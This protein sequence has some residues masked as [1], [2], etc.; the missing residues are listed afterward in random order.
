MLVYLVGSACMFNHMH[1]CY[2]VTHQLVLSKI[3]CHS[4]VRLMIAL[5]ALPKVAQ[6]LLPTD[7]KET[8]SHA[9]LAPLLRNEQVV[10]SK[11]R[12]C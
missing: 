9:P 8:Q 12:H 11:L 2:T 3:I 6:I 5:A 10:K 4:R 7:R 1:W